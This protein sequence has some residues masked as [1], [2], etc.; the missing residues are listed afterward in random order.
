MFATIDL[1][2]VWF[3]LSEVQPFCWM[4]FTAHRQLEVF[5]RYHSILVQIELIKE[6]LEL[7]ISQV[8]PPMLEVES[9]LLRQD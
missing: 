3:I 6:V 4:Y 1:L 8:E 9:Q 5:I 7:L 2:H